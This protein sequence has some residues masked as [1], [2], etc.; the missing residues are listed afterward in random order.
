MKAYKEQNSKCAI[1]KKSEQCNGV[2]GEIKELAIDHD[3]ASGK[4]RGLLCQSC[5]TGLGNFKDDV[6]ILCYAIEYLEEFE[7]IL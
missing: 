5:N 3:P 7:G 4:L 2:H 6:G 1:C